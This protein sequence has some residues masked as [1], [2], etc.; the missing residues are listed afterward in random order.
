MMTMRPATWAYAEQFSPEAEVIEAARDR[1]EQLGCTPV[2]TGTGAALRMLAA[3]LPARA[4][5][6]VGTGAGVSGLWLMQG[7]PADG[8]LTTIDISR[9]HQQ[10]ARQAF[11]D[12]GVPPQRTRTIVGNALDVMSRLT[13]GGYDLVLV[14]GDK[15]EYP[16]YVEQALRLLRSGGVLAIDN[17]LWHDKVADP[18]ARDERTSVLRDL[19]KQLRDDPKLIA[20]LLPVGD[21]LFV[22][23]KR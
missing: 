19:G 6:E 14:D 1:A 23:V 2:G 21:G 13:D 22:A 20:T 15:T 11:A 10:A 7:M 18:A 5:V 12:A 3:T 9:E 4:V 8:T 16:A 17:M